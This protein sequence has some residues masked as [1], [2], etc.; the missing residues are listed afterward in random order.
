MNQ[1]KVAEMN[2]RLSNGDIFQNCKNKKECPNCK[3]VVDGDHDNFCWKCGMT[4][5]QN[6]GTFKGKMKISPIH[7]PAFVL[8]GNW[9]YKAEFDCWYM[10]GDSFPAEI[11]R[12][13]EGECCE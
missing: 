5:R 10:G 2:K 11:C 13:M 7:R 4:L 6:T 9:E 3:A 12:K 8:E 1:Q